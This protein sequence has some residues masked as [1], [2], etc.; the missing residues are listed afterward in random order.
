MAVA[1]DLEIL[2]EGVETTHQRDRLLE[3]GIGRG[4]GYLF[5]RPLPGDTYA[6]SYLGSDDTAPVTTTDALPS[7]RTTRKTI[8]SAE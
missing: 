2:A 8:V 6:D 7:P 5:S 1:L 4:Q 3:L